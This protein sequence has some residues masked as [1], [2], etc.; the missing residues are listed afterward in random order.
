MN[1]K[2]LSDE[3]LP[4]RSAHILK[5]LVEKHIEDGQPVG[6]RALVSDGALTLSSA[7]VRNVLSDLEAR[8]YLKSPHTSAGRVPTTEGYRLFVDHLLTSSDIEIPGIEQVQSVLASN[9]DP[10]AI[11][12]SASSIISDMTQLTGIV[13]LPGK[14]DDRLKQ[15]DFL[16]LNEKQV[17]A[18]LVL[19][20]KEV[21][22]HI[23]DTEREYDAIELNEASN[24]LKQ[25]FAGQRI[26]EI[27]EK[28]IQLMQSEKESLT[29]SM[30]TAI[31]VS[32]KAL[33]QSKSEDSLLIRGES[34]LLDAPGETDLSRL[35]DLFEAFSQKRDII[36]L[37]DKCSRSKS[38]Q[39]F[40]GKESGNQMFKDLSLVS[41][42]YTVGEEVV[43]VLA[44]VGPR[45]IPYQKV[46]PTV[47]IT[48]KILDSVLNQTH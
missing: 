25:N 11:A 7:T 37:L 12:E 1:K 5:M 23:I 6:S 48:A 42:P 38:M 43:G 2:T 3:K 35:K 36:D 13:M 16:P 29:K 39:I 30:E 32:N 34:H 9:S 27:K 17:L 22:N 31:E 10:K 41:A 46:I 21:Q 44:V 33:D 8:G 18:I 40:I 45:R 20:E 14:N 4:E 19:N 47:N 15:I 28:L 24:Y 26:T